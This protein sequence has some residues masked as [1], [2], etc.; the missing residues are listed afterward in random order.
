MTL[1]CKL[2]KARIEGLLDLREKIAQEWFFER[3]V[4]RGRIQTPA[5]QFTE[6]LPELLQPPLGG[7]TPS[8]TRLQA[9]GADFRRLHV[10][11]LIHSSARSD[12]GVEYEKGAVHNS[13]GWLPATLSRIN[14]SSVDARLR[15]VQD[16]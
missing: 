4:H 16:S 8:N 6:I 5:T 1:G 14:Y 7:S 15:I 10:N 12:V 11:A 2:S 13:K 3:Y 9:I